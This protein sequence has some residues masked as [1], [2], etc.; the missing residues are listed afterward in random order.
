MK[1]ILI[2]LMGSGKTTIGK[3]LSIKLGYK[4]ID[5]DDEIEKSEG[6][7]IVEIFEKYGEKKFRDLETDLLKKII[8]QDDVIISTGG[9]IIKEKINREL[10]KEQEN[11]IFLDGN[12]T[13][14][15]NHL[16][17]ECEKRP[18]LK[19]TDDLYKK[20]EELLKERYEKYKESSRIKIDI[21]NKNINEVVSQILVYTR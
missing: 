3:E 6:M 8:L 17:F 21:N 20:I 10:L 14:L 12:I 18:L 16:S 15:I 2:G 7:T 1:L 19:N 5:M 13:T 9:G 4:F 11:V